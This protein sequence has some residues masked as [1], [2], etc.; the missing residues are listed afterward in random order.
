MTV[1]C[2]I[3]DLPDGGA[4][5]FEVPGLACKV[6]VV[7]K[8]ESVHGWRDFCPHYK[9]GTPMAWKRD[10]Y[11]NGP[12]THIACHAH[13]A[14]FDIETGA[15]VQGPCLGRRLIRVPL[16]IDEAGAVSMRPREERT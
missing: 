8:G 6:I 10:A 3:D 5:G 15:C 14:L 7:R 13:G 1:L 9:G 12:R 11:L 2:R 4:R 16:T